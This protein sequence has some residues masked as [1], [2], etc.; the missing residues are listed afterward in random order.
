MKNLRSFCSH[1]IGQFTFSFAFFAIMTLLLP[2]SVYA[3]NVQDI[4]VR[5][6]QRIAATTIVSY[7]GLSLGDPLNDR[8]TDKALKNLFSTGLFADV[9]VRGSGNTVYVDVVENPIVNE[10]VF[11]GNKDIK[12]AELLG[13]IQIR[14]RQ[15]FTR[16]K[17]QSD[18]M[19]LNQLYRRQGRFSASIQPK[20]IKLDQNRVNLV[21]EIQEGGITK[22]KSVR[23]VGN[24]KYSD[25]KLRS[26]ISSKQR[27]WYRFFSSADRYDADRLAFDQELLRNFY[28]SQG[29]ADFEILSAVS[30]LSNNKDSFFVTIT[31]DEGARYKF[32]D[33]DVVADIREFDETVLYDS[34]TFESGEWYDADEIRNTVQKMTDQLG[35]LQFAFVDIRPDVR[36]DRESREISVTFNI[37]ETPRVFVERINVNGN[38]RTLD[39]VLRREMELV[40]GDP[41]NRTKLAASERN[42]RNLDFFES[43]DV[44]ISQGSA[45]DKTVVDVNVQEKSTGELSIGAGISSEDGPLGDIRIR[46]RNLLGRGQDLLLATTI[47]AERSQVDLSFTE[48]YFLQRDISA[49]FDLFHV[50][51]DFQDESSFDQ[52]RTGGGLRIGYPLSQNWRQTLRYN[53]ERN[54]ITDVQDDASLFIANQEGTRTTSSLSQR[55]FYDTRDSRLF[56]TRGMTY[57]LDTT[58]AGL[59]G[60]AKFVSARTGASHYQPLTDDVILNLSAEVG[61]IQSYGGADVEINERFFLGD[62]SL[63]GFERSGVGPRDAATGDALGGNIF[64]RGSAE[65][66]FPIGFPDELGIRGHAFNDVG[67]LFEIDESGSDLQE[68]DSL[69]ASVGVGLSWRS[70]FGPI[71]LDLAVPYLSED[72]D[73]EENF[74]FDFGTRF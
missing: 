65:L 7:T 15:V 17:V 58:L 53:F 16:T 59:G 9:K 1:Y 62:R 72:F 10:V 20:I 66:S 71:R 45:P 19:R 13:E 74:R 48:P 4:E 6:A 43:M 73:E 46:E 14:P 39:K 22:I 61:G 27:A 29:F 64:Y 68:E 35:D 49:G 36:K 25:A 5:G 8:A 51:R 44:S 42:L 26:I 40:E 28:F 63:R 56:T 50:E 41:F 57:W 47:A 38:I 33:T 11:E 55:L 2:S 32:K 69:R 24:K 60:N 52:Q 70:P 18:V 3:Q 21:F 54:E 30:E 12:D 23:F 67:S 31:V 34:I 37:A